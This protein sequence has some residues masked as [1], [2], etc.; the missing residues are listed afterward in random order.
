MSDTEHR[1]TAEN[2]KQAADRG[3]PIFSGNVCIPCRDA[4]EFHI[5]DGVGLASDSTPAAN[6]TVVDFV[7]AAHAP[8]D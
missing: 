3:Y 8:T 6:G 4:T 7:Y 5:G 1:L 2:C